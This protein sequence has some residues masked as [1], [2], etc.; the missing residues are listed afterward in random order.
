MQ[1]PITDDGGAVSLLL[2]RVRFVLG[3]SWLLGW[4]AHKAIEETEEGY[5]N[6]E[7]PLVGTLRLGKCVGCA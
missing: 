6:H 5:F 4:C 1:R 7:P 3:Q 2:G